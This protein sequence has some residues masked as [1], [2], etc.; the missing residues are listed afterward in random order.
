MSLQ[1]L[2]NEIYQS[3]P[4]LMEL[5][6]GCEIEENHTKR[7]FFILGKI[8]QKWYVCRQEKVFDY[9]LHSDD[10][11]TIGK[12]IT[13]PD[14]L[15]WLKLNKKEVRRQWTIIDDVIEL[16]NLEKYTIDEQSVEL[17]DL[18]F[19]LKKE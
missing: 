2:K 17:I 12:P 1:Q 18:L 6:V 11:T 8:T 19:N 15:R 4:D 3:L 5:G 7:R 9:S 16:W 13:L 14:V 10:F